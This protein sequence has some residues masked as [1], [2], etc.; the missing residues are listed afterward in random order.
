[1]HE[2]HAMEGIGELRNMSRLAAQLRGV[3]MQIEN[4]RLSFQG[5]AGLEYDGRQQ[6]YEEELQ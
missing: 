6:C 2:L 5:V 4:I 3:R 1:M